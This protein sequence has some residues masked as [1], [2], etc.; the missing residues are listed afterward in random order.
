M[1]YPNIT[2]KKVFVFSDI[3]QAVLDGLADAGV[4]IHENRFTYEKRG[5]VLL[6]DLGQYWSECAAVPIPLG[7]IMAH[8]RLPQEIAGKINRLVRKSL[9]FA[10]ENPSGTIPYMRKYAQAMEQD[11]LDAHLRTFVNEFSLELGEEG[12]GAIKILIDKSIAA[13]LIND[14]PEDYFVI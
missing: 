6:R 2:E 14:I 7:G 13:G 8:R 4:L 5:L 3:E 1:A 9:E 10:F 11:V 12:K